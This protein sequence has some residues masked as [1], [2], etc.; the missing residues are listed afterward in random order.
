MPSFGI[1]LRNISANEFVRYGNN[2]E[3]MKQI[4]LGVY[5]TTT[6]YKFIKTDIIQKARKTRT[7]HLPANKAVRN[8]Y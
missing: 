1:F 6:E 4:N 8:L 7:Q 2:E 3:N 5:L